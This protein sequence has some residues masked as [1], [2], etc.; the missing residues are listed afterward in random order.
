MGG[1]E[2]GRWGRKGGG[3][4]EEVRDEEER[5]PQTPARTA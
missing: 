2:G 1:A 4:M 5:G 3:E